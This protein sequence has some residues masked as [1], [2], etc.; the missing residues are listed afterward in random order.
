MPDKYKTNDGIESYRNYYRFDKPHIHSWTG[1][2]AGRSIPS[3][4]NN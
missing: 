1:K 2:I 4:I 3:W